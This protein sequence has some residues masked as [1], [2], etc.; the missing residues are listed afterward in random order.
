MTIFALADCNNFYA[1]C[2]RVFNPKL[3]GKPVVVLSNNDGC[4]IARSNEAKK[5]GIPMGAP[6]YKWHPFCKKYHVQVFSS[7]YE[8]Y[9]DMS[10]RVMTVLESYCPD[11]E[12]YSIDEAF[13]L[14][15]GFAWKDLTAY[16]SD[17]KRMI[18]MSIGLPISIGFAQTKTL[19]KIANHV[20]KKQIIEGV[21]NLCDLHLQDQILSQFS[22][23][24]IWGVGTALAMRLKKLNIQTAR[25]LRDADPKMLRLHFNV[26]MEKIVHELRGISCLSLESVQPRQQIISSR[27]FGKQV[28]NLAY[29]EEAVSHYAAIASAKLREQKS[30]AGGVYVFLHTNFF[31]EN[32]TQYANA[33]SFWFSIPTADTGSIIHVAK[34]CLR[35]IYRK[36]YKY[37]KAGLMLLNLTPSSIKQYDMLSSVHPKS[38]LLM[39]TIDLINKTWGRRTIFH[40]AEGV[41]RPWQIKSERR[42]PRYTT[43]WSDLPKVYC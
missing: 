8:L 40:C 3:E 16:T 35:K 15:D 27:S 25:D 11:I 17:I 22:V 37:H 34:K 36:G 23:E 39:A 28:T 33:Q 7:N 41:A 1:S 31:R 19:A 21:F 12:I 14:L 42:S 32:D 13:L 30:V 29:L 5:I 38:E 20:A 24:N 10:H 2:E 6:F 43:R 4:I 26:T 9:G 18:K